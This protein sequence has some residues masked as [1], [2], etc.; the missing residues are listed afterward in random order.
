MDG[1]LKSQLDLVLYFGEH[2]PAASAT[3]LIGLLQSDL[4]A[5]IC[6]RSTPRPCSSSSCPGSISGSTGNTETNNNHGMLW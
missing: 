4:S 5:T 6:S 1:E 3:L 2:H